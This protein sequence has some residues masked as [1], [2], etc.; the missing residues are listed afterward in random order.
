M[1]SMGQGDADPGCTEAT[2]MGHRTRQM[3][4]QPWGNWKKASIPHR[5]HY[6]TVLALR[7]W[8]GWS[9]NVRTSS[10]AGSLELTGLVLCLVGARSQRIRSKK[11]TDV[12]ITG[13]SQ[14][15][16]DSTRRRRR[17]W[18]RPWAGLTRRRTMDWTTTMLVVTTTG[19]RVRSEKC[20]DVEITGLSQFAQDSTLCRRRVWPRPWA[21]LAR[22]QTIGL[23]VPP[24]GLSQLLGC[25]TCASSLRLAGLLL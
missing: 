15:A 12:E 9:C 19:R 8:P 5:Q 24:C 6:G 25:S 20:T 13:L 22:R 23:L 21:G 17:V 14:F 2:W 11:C 18:P 3:S 10:A 7:L 16:Q 4:M 1:G